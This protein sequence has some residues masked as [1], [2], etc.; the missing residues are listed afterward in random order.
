MFST[1]LYSAREP[2]EA[3]SNS[4]TLQLRYPLCFAEWRKVSGMV[5][6]KLIT[7]TLHLSVCTLLKTMCTFSCAYVHLDKCKKCQ[8]LPSD[9]TFQERFLLLVHAYSGAC[10]QLQGAYIL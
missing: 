10:T 3:I 5:P 8:A 9:R 2:S 1:I 4:C 6:V 7:C